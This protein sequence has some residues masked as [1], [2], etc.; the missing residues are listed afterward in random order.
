MSN[1]QSE[2]RLVESQE[3]IVRA[4]QKTNLG[5]AI[6]VSTKWKGEWLDG[7]QF[8]FSENPFTRGEILVLEMY[9]PTTHYSKPSRFALRKKAT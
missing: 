7:C 4:C 2:E 1:E 8:Y 9:Q 5:Y 6:G 3:V